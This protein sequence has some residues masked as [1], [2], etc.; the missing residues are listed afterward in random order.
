MTVQNKALVQG[1]NKLLADSYTVF[2]QTQ[3]YHWNVTGPMFFGLHSMFEE[4]Y[5]E[6]FEAIDEIAERIRSLGAVAPGSMAEFSSLTS[7][8]VGQATQ[9]Q[10]MITS[11]L[12]SQEA[13]VETSKE[14]MS[15]AEEAGDEVSVDLAIGRMTVHEKTAWMLRSLAA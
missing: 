12:A 3:N 11:L 8:Q 9:A 4:Q 2:L 14:V 1:L 5:T 6:L 10:D 13:L 15:L 7:V